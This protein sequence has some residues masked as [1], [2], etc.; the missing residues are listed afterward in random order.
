MN[1]TDNNTGDTEVRDEVLGAVTDDLASADFDEE[2][3][4]LPSTE[5]LD[6]LPMVEPEKT[7][8]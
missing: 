8:E 5:V 7:E 4:I 6:I 3:E 2:K 1:T